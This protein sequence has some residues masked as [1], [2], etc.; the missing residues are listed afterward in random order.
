MK[1]SLL[2][3]SILFFQNIISAQLFKKKKKENELIKKEEQKKT[4]TFNEI[5]TKEAKTYKGLFTVHNVANKWYFELNDSLFN[6]DIM[7]V[8]RFSKTVAA[9]GKYGGEEVNR[10]VVRWEKGPNKSLFLKSITYVTHS[11]DSTKPIALAVKNSDIHPI[12]GS[13]EIAASRKDTSVL[14]D[15]TDY[16]TGDNIIFGLDPSM[17]DIQKINQFQKD[18]SYIASIKSF[19]INIELKT[20]KTYEAVAY[21]ANGLSTSIPA[22]QNTGY[23]TFELNTSFILLPKVPMRK[24]F[25]DNRVGY[26]ANQLTR[27]GEESQRSE[28]EIYITRWRLEPKNEADAKLQSNGQLIEPKKPIVYYIDP[29]TPEKWKKYIKAGVDDWATAFEQAG[30]K[31]AIRGE[32]WPEKDSTMSLEDARFSVIRYFASSIQNAYGPNVNDPRTGE[33]LESHIGWYHNIMSLLHDWYFIQTSPNDTRAQKREFDDKLMGELIQFVSSHEI[34]HTLGLR[35]NMGA[36]H[37]TPVEKLR[38]KNWCKANGHTSSIM[39]YARFNYVAQPKDS[40]KDLFPR[41]GDYD[42][43]AIQWGYTYF[44]D[45]KDAFVEKSILHQLT[46]EKYANPRLRFGTE[47]HPTDPRYQTEDLSDDAMKASSYGIEN[48]KRIV[49]NLISWTSENGENYSELKEM[50]T[51]VFKQYV[52]YINHVSKHIGGIYENP[53]TYDMKGNSYECVPK[54]IQLNA[55]KFIDDNVLKTPKWLID[56]SILSKIKPETGIVEKIKTM[57]LNN[58]KNILSN[59]K[60]I[61]IIECSAESKQNLTLNELFL[62][63]KDHVFSEL[64]NNS[65]IDVYRRNLQLNYIS[66]LENMTDRKTRDYQATTQSL[67]DVYGIARSSLESIEKEIK[68][69]LLSVKDLQTKIHLT[70]LKHIINEILDGD[71]INKQ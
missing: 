67:T 19:P 14:I 56:Q 47:N 59:D 10:Q 65:E 9:C 60:L 71:K 41:I 6:C 57:Q 15:V 26:F 32:Y 66:I 49:P 25:Y 12:I 43:W 23:V 53:K 54:E 38:D 24:R 2:I 70:Q 13:F 62:F 3:L 48:L 52:L 45:T 16:F 7:S 68:K 20:V 27:Y 64:K 8:T 36:S 1:Y 44:N 46:K 22:A 40:V 35:H 37:A 63:L 55:L 18:K 4:K 51:N 39:D 11:P 31:N 50:Y 61:R 42:K 17:K 30:W 21:S 5:I 29:A 34:G 69:T 28:E 33:I 58:L